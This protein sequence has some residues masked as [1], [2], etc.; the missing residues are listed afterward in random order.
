MISCLLL[1]AI[2]AP[3]I[4]L[5]YLAMRIYLSNGREEEKLNNAL[6]CTK[7]VLNLCNVLSSDIKMFQKMVMD[8]E[9]RIK[10]LES[11]RK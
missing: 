4:F 1:I 8:L 9:D 10:V 2:T 3:M 7:R 5:A 11:K 6:E